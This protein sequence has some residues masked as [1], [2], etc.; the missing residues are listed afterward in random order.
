MKFKLPPLPYAKDALEPHMSR[1][2]LEYHYEKHHKGYLE[3]LEAAIK[4]TPA[5]SLSLEEIIRTSKGD[6]YNNA[7][8][9]WNHTFFWE[10]MKPGGGDEPRG[11]VREVVNDSFGSFDA[12]RR[13]FI[14]AGTSHFGSGYVWLVVADHRLECMA[15]RDAETPL[16]EGLAP[17]LTCDVWEHAYYLDHHHEREKYLEVFMDELVDWERVE[18]RL[19]ET[20]E[21]DR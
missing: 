12:L 11:R 13:T 6:V 4:G 1:D 21:N 9:V 14:D 18:E 19:A 8:Q 17:I 10:S 7:A 15:K 16:A 3:K 2:T 20:H 5:A